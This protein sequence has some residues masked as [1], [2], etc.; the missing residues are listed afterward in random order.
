MWAK[1]EPPSSYTNVWPRLINI[2]TPVVK[3]LIENDSLALNETCS[4]TKFYV[5]CTTVI[6]L[7]EFKEKKKKNNMDK[8]GKNMFSS[9]WK[10]KWYFSEIFHT[11]FCFDKFSTV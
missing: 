9:N 4:D 8:L 3:G 1:F 11:Q 10:R 7:R 6:E 5:Y 2:G